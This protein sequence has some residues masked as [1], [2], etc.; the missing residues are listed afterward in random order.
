MTALPDDGT[1]VV[2][3]CFLYRLRPEAAA[4]YEEFHRAVWPEVKES[5]RRS[6]IVDYA[7]YRRGDLVISVVTRDPAIPAPTPDPGLQEKVDEW[8]ALMAPLF[9][10]ISDESG[11]L[12]YADQI[13]RL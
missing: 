8:S 6:G 3:E 5:L 11:R 1:A 10:A 2:T 7:I 12:L 4:A 13:F 9:S